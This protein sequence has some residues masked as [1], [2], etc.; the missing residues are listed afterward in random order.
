[1]KE[2]SRPQEIC[3]A[4]GALMMVVGTGCYVFNVLP[5]LF[6]VV[7]FL[8]AV[9][10]A[11]MQ[12]VATMSD[13]SDD[14]TL[15]RLKKI[16]RIADVCFIIAGLMMLENAYM[17][18]YNVI[19]LDIWLKYCWNNWVIVLLVAAILEMYTSHR[20]SYELKKKDR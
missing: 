1:M 3:L 8:G 15:R 14:M 2:L 20:I 9:A 10:F 17:M 11:S 16:M 5:K 7:F 19:P 12:I 13:G 6:S 4:L 18:L